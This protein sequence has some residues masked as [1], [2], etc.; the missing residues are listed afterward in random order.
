M[1]L[2]RE[3]ADALRIKEPRDTVVYLTTCGLDGKPNLARQQFTD[4]LD[5][6]YIL[7]PDL[8]AQKTK[9]NLNE[10][11]AAA[12]TVA[13]PEALR[14]WVI[15]GPCNIFQWGHPAGYS[16]QGLKAGFILS[17]WGEW[18]R[19]ESLNALPDDLRPTVFAQRGV[20]VLRAARIFRKE[21]AL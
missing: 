1:K 19:Q 17:G 3:L 10:N 12:L 7:M 18:D 21:E 15:E 6:E 4:I 13:W 16:F 5:D 2:P 9:V 11:L 14:G 8:F 20:I